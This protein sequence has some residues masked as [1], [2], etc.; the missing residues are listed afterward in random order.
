MDQTIQVNESQMAALQARQ[1]SLAAQL[2]RMR[3]RLL[4]HEALLREMY[5]AGR[6]AGSM[7]PQRE[8]E[9]LS[10]DDAKIRGD[11]AGL[12]MATQEIAAILSQLVELNRPL[13][14]AMTPLARNTEGTGL[15]ATYLGDHRLLV[16]TRHQLPLV[17]DS[18]DLQITPSLCL[19]GMWEPALTSLYQAI[20]KPG[21]AYLEAGA[22]IGYFTTLATALVG[23]TGRVEAFEPN[24]FSYALLQENICLNHMAYLVKRYRAALSDRAGQREFYCFGQNGASSTLSKLPDKLLGEFGEQPVPIQVESIRLDDQYGGEDQFD[25]VKLDAEGAEGLILRGGE[26]FFERS[27]TPGAVVTLEYN[28]PAARGLG[29]DPMAAIDRLLEL[30]F[31]LVLLTAEG[32]LQPYERSLMS[33]WSNAQ[34][35][36]GRRHWP[37]TVGEL[38]G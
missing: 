8:G 3:V 6:S 9:Q 18:R 27:L 16:Q 12:V 32:R 30:G 11:V 4:D 33:T 5:L 24:P 21:Q 28:P 23:H 17:C 29:L 13:E 2:D 7:A 14:A 31:R 34:V 22:Y 20:L 15:S 38:R 35:V 26:R 19:Q 36:A 1:N 25:F 10:M 37:A